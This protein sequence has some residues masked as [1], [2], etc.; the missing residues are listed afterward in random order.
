MI[1]EVILP[2]DQILGKGGG[3]VAVSILLR[4]LGILQQHALIKNSE[5]SVTVRPFST[6]VRYGFDLFYEFD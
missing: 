1:R 6:Q 2:G 5:E 3:D 4:G